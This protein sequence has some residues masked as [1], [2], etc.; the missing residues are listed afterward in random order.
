MVGEGRP[1]DERPAAPVTSEGEAMRPTYTIELVPNRP[2]RVVEYEPVEGKHR[3]FRAVRVPVFEDL[4]A[5]STDLRCVL[6]DL[7][8]RLV[9]V[10]YD[11]EVS[12]KL[13]KG[14][15]EQG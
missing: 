14:N 7:T 1:G 12:Y 3:Q 2:P 4:E 9:S 15:H 10:L 11:E 6:E 5:A 8:D 13:K